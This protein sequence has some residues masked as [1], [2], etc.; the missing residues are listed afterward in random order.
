MLF[1]TCIVVS[2]IFIQVPP[3]TRK[4][5]KILHVSTLLARFIKYLL[6]KDKQE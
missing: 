6:H 2:C 1:L 5:H 3:K 4:N